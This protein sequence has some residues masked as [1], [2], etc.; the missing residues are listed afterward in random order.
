MAIPAGHPGPRSV[1]RVTA[2]VVALAAVLG[3]GIWALLEVGAPP[4]TVTMAT[5]P[6]GSAYAVLGERYR[7]ILARAGIQLRLVP[8]AGEAENLAR[9]GD[10]RSGVGVAF[11]ISGLPEAPAAQ[12]LASLGAVACAPLWLFQPASSTPLG[13]GGLAGRRISLGLEGS[14]TQA[15]ARRLFQVTGLDASGAAVVQLGPDEAAERLLRGELD[16][17]AMVADWETPAV[18]RLVADPRVAVSSYQRA[19]ALVALNPDLRK[20]TLPAGAGD[21]AAGRPAVD[22]TLVATKVSLLVREDLHDA[23]QF[24]LLDAASKVHARPGIFHEAGSFPAAEAI[25]FPLSD[26]ANRYFKAGR[27]FL[28]RHLPFWAAVLVERLLF[29]LLPILAVLVPAFSGLAGLYSGLMR[30]RILA[31]YGGLRLVEHDLEQGGPEADRQALLQRLGELDRR[32]SRLRV[33]VQFLQ[34]VYTLKAH[35]R[36]VRERVES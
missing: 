8:T 34:M 12:G 1:L 35:L 33:P 27:P 13:P 32:A 10:P 17:V 24:L 28:Q 18:R 22:V 5:G 30:Q 2:W 15:L 23:L 26:E 9:L 6:A 16:L 4:R 20:L 7:T 29:V 36:Q 25:D 21:F 14:G 11:A 31:L 3:C 19:D